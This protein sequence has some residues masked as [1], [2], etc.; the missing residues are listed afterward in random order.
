MLG[1]EAAGGE[2]DTPGSGRGRGAR[3]RA[4]LQGRGA[5]KTCFDSGESSPARSLPPALLGEFST[6]GVLYEGG[7]GEERSHVGRPSWKQ[8]PRLH[9]RGPQPRRPTA[10]VPPRSAAARLGVRVRHP[11]VGLHPGA[12]RAV[13]AKGG[14]REAEGRAEERPDGCPSVHPLRPHPS[15]VRVSRLLPLAPSTPRPTM[16][17]WAAAV[18]ARGR[19]WVSIRCLLFF[20]CPC[21]QEVLL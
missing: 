16:G 19:L 15:P 12:G 8:T 20:L 3:T 5:S 21:T 7:G 13:G 1:E 11:V 2:R 4:A 17:A 6:R 9:P 18:S 14:G 10:W